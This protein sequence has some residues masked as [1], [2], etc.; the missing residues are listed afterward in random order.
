MWSPRS[1]DAAPLQGV[2]TGDIIPLLLL[3]PS[4]VALSDSS[5]QQGPRAESLKHNARSHG[6]PEP[7]A[8]PAAALIPHCGLPAA[9]SQCGST[10]TTGGL[11]VCICVRVFLHLHVG[12]RVCLCV[13]AKDQR[14]RDQGSSG[15]LLL[16]MLVFFSPFSNN[17]WGF[18]LIIHRKC[19]VGFHR[20]WDMPFVH[21]HIF[22]V[23]TLS[24]QTRY[25]SVGIQ[26]LSMDRV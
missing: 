16:I 10:C 5:W 12:G 21:P 22:L 11:I 1:C 17:E 6:V 9:P 15:C 2:Q 13:C 3:S 7:R 19:A 24:R 18:L 8:T 4:P 26:Q 25:V 23:L 14:Q 20:H